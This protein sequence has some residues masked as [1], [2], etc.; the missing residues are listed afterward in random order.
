MRARLS[1]LGF[2]VLLVIGLAML[3][4]PAVTA[5]DVGTFSLSIDA[6]EA[7]PGE[8]VTVTFTLENTGDEPSAAIVAVSERPEG[9]ELTAHESD[10][11][12]WQSED[13]K[14]LFQT[15]EAGATVEPSITLSVPED[16][17]GEFT[18]AGNVTETDSS[19]TAE[20]TLSV[21]EDG[22][23][24][25]ADDDSGSTS[26]SGPGFGVV[27]ALVALLGIGLLARRP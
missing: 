2:S 3:G 7:A 20:T 1:G 5:Q 25:T 4:V 11:G 17:N 12:V 19:T 18:I 15:V 23:E 22:S 13:E 16:A 8:E 21:G 10:G 9:W 6:S 27:A 14:W 26:L 24:E